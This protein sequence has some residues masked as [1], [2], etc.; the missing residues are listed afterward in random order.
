MGKGIAAEMA[1][2]KRQK[3][4]SHSGRNGG[5]TAADSAEERAPG[6]GRPSWPTCRPTTSQA[7]SPIR[8]ARVRY[9]SRASTRCWTTWRTTAPT[10]A[11][12]S[13][14]SCVRRGSLLPSPTSSPI[15][16]Q[17]LEAYAAPSLVPLHRVRH[18][19]AR[20][21][22]Q[23]GAYLVRKALVEELGVVEIPGHPGFGE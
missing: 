17:R 9:L 7:P 10:T 20:Q 2:S 18:P 23:D 12:R 21:L 15:S 16:E 11:A 4:R 6:A 5:G 22:F 13:S 1:L 3:W 14:F 8:T 19:F